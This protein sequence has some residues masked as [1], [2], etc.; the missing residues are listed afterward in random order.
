MNS[1]WIL[2]AEDNLLDAD[3]ATRALCG[4]SDEVEVVLARD[5]LEALD[6]LHCRGDFIG[7]E[8]RNPAVVLLDLK[9][10]L[11]DGFEVLR[12]IKSIEH[13]RSTPV[14]V[15]SSSREEVDVARCYNLG[16]NAY[17]VKPVEFRRYVDV[18]KQIRSFWLNLNQPQQ[19]L[20]TTHYNLEH[21]A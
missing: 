12:E 11:V 20:A 16:A 17:V 10:P 7:R 19:D 4:N 5:G 9:M 8:A 3:L 14:V 21:A 2:L 18:L 13:L 1:K 15:F 6:C